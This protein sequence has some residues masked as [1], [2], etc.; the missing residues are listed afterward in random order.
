[1]PSETETTFEGYIASVNERGFGF[2]TRPGEP[3]LFF[4]CKSLVGGLVFDEQLRQRRVRF[5]IR[6]DCGRPR[7]IEVGPAY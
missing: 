3:D 1:M 4:H 7:A 2:I 5:R 6:D